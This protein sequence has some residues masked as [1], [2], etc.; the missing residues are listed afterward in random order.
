M[1]ASK[2]ITGRGLPSLEYVAKMVNKHPN[3]IRNWHSDNF[4]LFEMVVAGCVK[5]YL[6]ANAQSMYN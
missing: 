5:K 6:S 1:I 4:I 3:T 2:Y